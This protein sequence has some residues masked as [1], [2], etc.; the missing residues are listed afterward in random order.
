VG[1]CQGA[2]DACHASQTSHGQAVTWLTFIPE[3]PYAG[4]H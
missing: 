1:L 4:L 3:L 2:S